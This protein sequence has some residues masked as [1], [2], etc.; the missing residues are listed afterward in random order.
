MGPGNLSVFQEFPDFRMSRIWNTCNS[1]L[2]CK[3]NW[4]KDIALN[5]EQL[6]QRQNQRLLPF[7]ATDS[8]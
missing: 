5:N 2:V 7:K 1:F 4:L 8:Y 6:K 3:Q